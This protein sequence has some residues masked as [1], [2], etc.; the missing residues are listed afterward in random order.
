MLGVVRAGA[1][2]W[3][4]APGLDGLPVT[5]RGQIEGDEIEPRRIEAQAVAARSALDIVE[6]EG[7]PAGVTGKQFHQVS[8]ATDRGIEC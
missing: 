8:L 3:V 6:I 4:R 7:V 2:A 1:E 5:V